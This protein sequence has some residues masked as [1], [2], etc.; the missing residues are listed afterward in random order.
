MSCNIRAG[1]SM[2]GFRRAY[3]QAWSRYSPGHI[4]D[5]AVMGMVEA[6]GGVEVFDTMADPVD[7]SLRHVWPDSVPICTVAIPS[8]GPIGSLAGL[9]ISAQG[10]RLR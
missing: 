10:R 2:F 8:I 5:V 7:S 4:L 6:I 9:L 3:D 1:K